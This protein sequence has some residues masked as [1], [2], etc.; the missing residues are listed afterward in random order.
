[1]INITNLKPYA[2]KTSDDPNYIAEIDYNDCGVIKCEIYTNLRFY[3]YDWLPKKDGCFQVSVFD[4]N[5]ARPNGN[6]LLRIETENSCDKKYKK[7]LEKE[8]KKMAHGSIFK[9]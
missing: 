7:D 9:N 4:H 5:F 2:R 6:L 3:F 8:L 1:M